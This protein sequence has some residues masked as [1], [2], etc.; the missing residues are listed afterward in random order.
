MG[1]MMTWCNAHDATR[2]QMT[3]QRHQITG[4]HLA[5]RSRGVTTL[6]H[7]ERISSRDLE[8]HRREN[9][10]ERE[11][12]KLSCFFDKRVRTKNIEKVEQYKRKSTTEMNEIANNLLEKRNKE[13]YDNLKVAKTWIKSLMD[14]IGFKTTPVTT[15]WERKNS[16]STPV[17][18]G[19]NEHG[20]N[21]TWTWEDGMILDEINNTLPPEQ[22]IEDRSLE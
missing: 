17:E 20:R 4:R 2:K 13:H 18:H 11:V 14:K 16:G 6:H 9:G 15:R 10:R 1:C 12:V 5:Q 22:R 3:W 19:R 21:R 7:Y 8:W